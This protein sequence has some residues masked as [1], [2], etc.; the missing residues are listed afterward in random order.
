[1]E[2]IQNKENVEKKVKPEDNAAIEKKLGTTSTKVESK[3]NATDLKQE[4]TQEQLA[5]KD[6]LEKDLAS[7]MKVSAAVGKRSTRLDSMDKW[8]T[9]LPF[10]GDAMTWSAGLLFFMAQNKQLSE[11]YK[12]SAGDKFKAAMLQ[13]GDR[14]F[15]TLLKSPVSLIQSIPIIWALTLPVTM[16]LKA[17]LWLIS[18]HIFKAN[19]WTA[20]LFEKQFEQMLKDANTWNKENPDK[21]QI[22]VQSM[23][24]EMEENM[25]KLKTKLDTKNVKQE[26]KE[27]KKKEKT[28]KEN[29]KL[30]KKSEKVE[31][32]EAKIEKVKQ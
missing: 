22:D 24:S 6:E 9:I 19:K 17:W 4:I 11:K 29:E 1:M 5:T 12:I 10:V 2:N 25:K 8:L 13:V 27:L 30:S 32:K 28:E 15:E 16:P 26:K 18:D 14:T 21:E 23:K 7:G 20:K 31:K 3:V